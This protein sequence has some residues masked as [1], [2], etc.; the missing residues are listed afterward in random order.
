[1]RPPR[2]RVALAAF[3][4]PA[5]L[6]VLAFVLRTAWEPRL[7]E[8]IA[9]HWGTD[10][11]DGSTGLTAFTVGTLV[12][13]GVLT[14]AGTASLLVLLRRGGEVRRGTVLL[15]ALLASLPSGMLIS[16]MA[17]SLDAESWR[18][19]AGPGVVL[20]VLLGTTGVA[21][22]VAVL[23]AGRRVPARGH[24]EPAGPGEASVGLK[25]GQRASWV[26][27]TTNTPLAGV[28]AFL[29]VLSVGVIDVLTDGPLGWTGYAVTAGAG[30]LTALM[31]PSLRA[32][33]DSSGIT[34]RM[35]LVGLPRTH[36]ALSDI[37]SA[38]TD[39][40]R[41][42]SLGGLGVRYDPTT[43]DVAYKIRG[44]SA[45]VVSLR[46][47]RRVF[48]TVDGPEQAAGLLN[49]LIRQASPARE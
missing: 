23:L 41:A 49:D 18:Q 46:D 47:G 43:G 2:P 13:A 10:G 44:G 29:P 8:V 6:A 5:L 40:V 22:G 28:C 25:P 7:P 9:T 4:V 19:A 15:H 11:V 30:V 45:L 12:A 39:T 26:G 27:G 36:L 21:T 1:M 42:T 3:G 34:I 31:V 33:V 38:G 37:A 17:A 14:S 20:L 48:V 16:S 35:G 24:A 32:V